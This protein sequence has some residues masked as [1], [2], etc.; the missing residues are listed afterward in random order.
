MTFINTNHRGLTIKHRVD[1]LKRD[2]EESNAIRVERAS[3]F[4]VYSFP[5]MSSLCDF[6]DINFFAADITL[7]ALSKSFPR[8]SLSVH[9]IKIV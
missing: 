1:F 5:E 9:H 7:H 3:Q 8:I 6:A 2:C 4:D